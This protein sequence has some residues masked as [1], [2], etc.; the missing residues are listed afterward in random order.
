MNNTQAVTLWQIGRERS[1]MNIEPK[2]GNWF[3]EYNY[4]IAIDRDPL[5]SP[6]IPQLIAIPQT[7]N[8]SNGTFST[9]KLNIYFTL[10][11]NYR[12]DELTLF[13]GCFGL[14]ETRFLLDGK[15]LLI[16]ALKSSSEE[17]QQ[18]EIPFPATTIGDHILTI[19]VS[20][21]EKNPD[22][23]VISYLKLEAL[24]GKEVDLLPV[25]DDW[26]TWIADKTLLNIM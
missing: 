16:P 18:L 24:Q 14:Q 5:D 15:P 11:R 20:G 8:S 7:Q 2:H 17:L 9:G 21:K 26:A 25:R 23:Q 3:S 19:T 6:T 22:Y 12:A 10:E 1:R 4:T 13:Y